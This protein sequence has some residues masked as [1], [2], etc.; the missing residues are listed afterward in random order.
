MSETTTSAES[1]VVDLIAGSFMGAAGGTINSI[2]PT[3]EEMPVAEKFEFDADFQTKIAALAMRDNE[4]MRR[5]AHLLKPDYFENIGEATMIG[6]LLSHFEKYHEIPDPSALG[7]VIK[8]ALAKGIIR[9]DIAP[10]AIG[11]VKLLRAESL[12]NRAYAEEKLAEFARHQAVS[13]AI[14]A[15]VTLLEKKKFPQIEAAIKQAIEIGINE[16]GD[17]YDYFKRAAIRS[18]MRADKIAGKMPPTGITTGIHRMDELLFHKGWGRRELATIMGGAKSGKTTALI[19]FAKAASLHGNHVLYVTLEVGAAIVEE[20]LDAC[21][22]DTLMKELTTNFK[23]VEAKLNALAARA[24]NLLIH[25][26]ASGTFKASMLRALLERYRSK[27]TNFD[28]VVVDYADIMAP[29]FRTDDSIQNSKSVY[30]DL[31]AI[32]FEFNCAGLTATQTNRDGH[33][34]T[35]AKAEHVSEDFNK[36]RTVDLMISINVTDEERKNGRARLYFA[37]SRNQESGFTIVIKQNLAM[38]KFVESVIGVE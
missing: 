9:R 18:E 16:E 35:V 31:R 26:Y 28:L 38:M 29:E 4:F 14:L 37:A 5:A 32:M 7:T 27:G 34:A 13:Q 23:S 1:A 22:T 10:L 17:A 24:G 33:K 25:E 3:S 19:N 30:I 15:S 21:V 12:A 20:R 11:A 6:V 2:V 36:V 8:E